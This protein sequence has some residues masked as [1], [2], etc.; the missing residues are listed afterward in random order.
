MILL[1]HPIDS[2]FGREARE[3]YWVLLNTSKS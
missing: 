1:S 3:T 2:E